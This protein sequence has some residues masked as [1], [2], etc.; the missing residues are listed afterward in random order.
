MGRAG[1]VM[2]AVLL[3][4]LLLS[5]H[6]TQAGPVAKRVSTVCVCVKT[7]WIQSTLITITHV[8]YLS[9]MNMQYYTTE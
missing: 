2:G 7:A 4:V 3:L 5:P 9:L 8:R 6:H 1:V